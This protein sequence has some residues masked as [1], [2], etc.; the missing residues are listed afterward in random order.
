MRTRAIRLDMRPGVRAKSSFG[1]RRQCQHQ[2][3][4]DQETNRW[5][6]EWRW[7]NADAAI[8]VHAS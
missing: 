5:P 2:L 4:G 7:K 8:E 6:P 1:Q 3:S